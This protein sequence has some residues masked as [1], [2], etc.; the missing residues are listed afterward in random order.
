MHSSELLPDDINSI[1]INGVKVRKGT[2]GAFLVNAS[3]WLSPDVDLTAKAMIEKDIIDA[4]PGLQVLGLFD[5]LTIND[6]GLRTLV[7]E[8]LMATQC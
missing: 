5:L 3:A 8:H 7:Q 4:L 1:N 2:V 6:V